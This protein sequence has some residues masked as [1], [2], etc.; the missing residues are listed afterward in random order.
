MVFSSP[1]QRIPRD[2]VP[3]VHFSSKDVVL[4][5]VA[6][7]LAEIG[8][9]PRFSPKLQLHAIK[10][11]GI[12]PHWEVT[13]KALQ[14]VSKAMMR[15]DGEGRLRPYPVTIVNGLE[16]GIHHIYSPL[17]KQ[18]V[19]IKVNQWN[20]QAA[21]SAMHHK[22]AKT[23][24]PDLQQTNHEV[25]QGKTWEKGYRSHLPHSDKT[26]FQTITYY[27]SKAHDQIKLGVGFPAPWR[28]PT[29][30]TV[31][32][33]EYDRPRPMDYVDTIQSLPKA[34]ITILM[35]DVGTASHHLHWGVSA[36]TV[37]RNMETRFYKTPYDKSSPYTSEDFL[38]P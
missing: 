24:S 5:P 30:Q 4:S 11:L 33:D 16:F 31:L 17:T 7:A 18:R 36:D 34:P 14:K 38:T 29:R 27:P 20:T 32:Y 26:D 25:L 35:Q 13:P 10:K 3:Q 28:Q 1:N 23:I 8:F 19:P 21:Y 12:I 9:H 2:M 6:H 22:L 37:S 15:Q